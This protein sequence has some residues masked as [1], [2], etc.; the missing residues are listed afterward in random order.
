MS[1]AVYRSFVVNLAASSLIYMPFCLVWHFIQQMADRI[2]L[3]MYPTLVAFNG[4]TILNCV[5]FW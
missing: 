2:S 5:F 1:L 4:A 3:A